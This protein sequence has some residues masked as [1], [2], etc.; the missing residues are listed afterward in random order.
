MTSVEL[1]GVDLHPLAETVEIRDAHRGE[2]HEVEGPGGEEDTHCLLN[3][4]VESD[5]ERCSLEW[6]VL[7]E[8]ADRQFVAGASG[9][10]V[11]SKR[12]K[13]EARD[14]DGGG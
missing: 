5:G 13:V 14:V 4:S 6:V 10:L 2:G 1:I 11:L 12:T 9:E 7:S 3:E 8:V